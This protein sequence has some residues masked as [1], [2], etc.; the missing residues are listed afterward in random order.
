MVST[1][2]TLRWGEARISVA[3]PPDRWNGK[4][5]ARGA[6]RINP[7][8]GTRR[9]A[10][11]CAW[12]TV[13]CVIPSS[14]WRVAVGLGVPLGWGGEHLRSERIPG[15]GTLYVIGL[16][17]G[18]I[19]AAGLTLGLVYRW[20]EVVPSGVPLIGRRRVPLWLPVVLAVSG[21]LFV[22]WLV[23]M[24]IRSWAQVSGFADQPRSGWALLM[25]AYYAPAALWP[26][27]LLAVTGAYVQRRR[28]SSL[29]P[30][31]RR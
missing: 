22:A 27:L 29:D 10:L 7:V 18:S 21:A 6:G 30:S 15:F 20:G 31:R 3:A 11:V 9:W 8:Q 5:V 12:A 16:S 14:L 2:H 13:A 25:A 19:L 26:A 24:S 1:R 23:W 17:I 4:G 28:R